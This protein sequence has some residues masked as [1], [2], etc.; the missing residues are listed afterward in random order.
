M[1]SF[2]LKFFDMKIIDT[3][4][5][6]IIFLCFIFPN[7][8]WAQQLCQN[9]QY[10][11]DRYPIIPLPVELIPQKGEFEINSFQRFRIHFGTVNLIIL[12]LLNKVEVIFIY[13]VVYD[14]SI[15]FF[16]SA[17]SFRL[18]PMK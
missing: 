8:I 5:F 7:Y 18:M 15:I 10:A 12:I 4:F 6:I 2:I 3:K 13:I 17:S 9:K 14:F 16:W 1:L 11:G